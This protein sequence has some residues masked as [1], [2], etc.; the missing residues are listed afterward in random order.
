MSILERDTMTALRK[1]LVDIGADICAGD[2]LAQP[3][4]VTCRECGQTMR[5]APEHMQIVLACPHCGQQFEPRS[6][7]A[8]QVRVPGGDLVHGAMSDTL[9]W[10]NR[11]VA[12][13]LGVLL[14]AFGVHRFYLGYTGIGVLQIILSLCTAGIAGLWGSIEG[15]LILVGMRFHDADG[16]PLRE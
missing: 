12:G 9:S 15:V 6:L 10:R 14:G 3:A 2:R 16:L 1:K 5:I 8:R 11:W 7:S 4:V 13:I